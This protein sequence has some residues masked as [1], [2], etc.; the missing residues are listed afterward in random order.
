MNTQDKQQRLQELLLE[1]ARPETKI[2]SQNL[3]KYIL[4]GG[5]FCC[6]RRGSGRIRL[7]YFPVA[8]SGKY[9]MIEKAITVARERRCAVI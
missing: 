2:T 7:A 4:R 3:E 1:L 9:D 8:E 5:L 6:Q